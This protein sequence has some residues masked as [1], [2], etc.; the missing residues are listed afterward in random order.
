MAAG[1]HKK[2]DFRKYLEKNGIIDALTK[3]L[4]GLYEEPEKPESA[5]DYVKQFLGG[6]SDVDVEA[7]RSENEELR[8]KVEELQQRVDELTGQSQAVAQD[9]AALAAGDTVERATQDLQN[10]L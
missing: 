9:S 4:V 7:V 2:E 10:S 6:A 3:V 5:M 8:R 1:D